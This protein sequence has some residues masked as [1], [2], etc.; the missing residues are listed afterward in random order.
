[1]AK[2][3]LFGCQSDDGGDTLVPSFGKRH[4]NM[5]AAIW[6]LAAVCACAWSLL[7]WGIHAVLTLDPHWVGELKDLID[8][9]P[10][11][12]WVDAV[13]PGW[14]SLLEWVIGLA[15]SLLVGFADAVPVV[16]WTLWG[17]GIFAVLGAAAMMHMLVRLSTTPSAPA[18]RPQFVPTAAAN[19]A[20]SF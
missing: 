1:M 20:S 2:P 5:I 17:A 15:Q 13:L 19:P 12:R 6:I 4:Y 16:V 9:V 7:A 14:E 8:R 10:L 3:G 11:A 18:R